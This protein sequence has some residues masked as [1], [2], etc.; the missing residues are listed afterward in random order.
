MN[1]SEL[2]QEVDGQ[3]HESTGILR[4]FSPVAPGTPETQHTKG[5]TQFH[6]LIVEIDPNIAAF[7]RSLI[8]KWHDWNVPLYPSHISVVRKEEIPNLDLW[9]KH[10]GEEVKFLYS[11]IVQMGKVYFWLNVFCKRLEEI[12]VELGL[13][14]SS[15]YTRPPEG[16]QKCFHTTIANNKTHP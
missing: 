7:Y 13:P 8:P 2:L 4:Y 16:F 14:V 5:P 11:P 1:F 3:L 10:E 9:G 6:K 15:P 12:R